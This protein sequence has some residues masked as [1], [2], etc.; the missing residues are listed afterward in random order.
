M[1]PMI[2]A[3]TL[4]TVLAGLPAYAAAQTAAASDPRD[5]NLNAYVELLRAD[6]R[7]QKSSF[8]TEMMEF[9]EAED[10][11][12][13]PIYR[14]YDAELAKLGDERISMIKEYSDRL[15]ALTGPQ[16]EALAERAIDIDQRR[17]RLLARCYERV[18]AATSPIVALRF[19]QVEH[20][21]LLIIDLQIS[22]ML[23]VAK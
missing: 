23:P 13:W 5:V 12:F 11:A 14:E 19:L 15:G 8:L 6:V 18:K 2:A 22:A 17:S 21:M 9:R 4:A 10:A 3:V 7:S 20:Q 1:T 16:A